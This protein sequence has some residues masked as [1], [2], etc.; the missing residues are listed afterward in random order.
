MGSFGLATSKE[1]ISFCVTG[2]ANIQALEG[3]KRSRTELHNGSCKAEYLAADKE[4]RKGTENGEVN[5]QGEVGPGIARLFQ[6][7][8]AVPSATFMPG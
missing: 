1:P 7:Y 2:L 5:C 6:H 8:L 4:D 3:I